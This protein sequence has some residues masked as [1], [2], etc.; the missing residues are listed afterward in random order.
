MSDPSSVVL[1]LED[2][3]QQ[4]LIYRY[5]I[6]CGVKCSAI[7]IQRSPSG[8]GSAE[9]WVRKQFAKEVSEYRRRH[10]QTQ[11]IVVIDADNHTVQERLGQLDQ[12]LKDSGKPPA[13]AKTE[14]IARLAPKRNI[15][16][17]V[18]CLNGQKVDEINDYKNNN[19]WDMLIPKA[20][21]VLSQW[22]RPN[23]K[24]PKTCIASLRHGASELG[25]LRS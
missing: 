12:E 9:N 19:D 7:R 15:E 10:A 25:R 2:E 1:L 17:W 4:R 14:K 20:A 21:E 24:P 16:T 23:A 5:L 13:D 11:L 6:N 3:H 22:S 8:R 18:L